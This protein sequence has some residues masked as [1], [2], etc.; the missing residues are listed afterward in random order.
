LDI[1]FVADLVIIQQDCIDNTGPATA[2]QGPNLLMCQQHGANSGER[3]HPAIL[4]RQ[5]N[6]SASELAT[7]FEPRIVQWQKSSV[8]S[9]GTSDRCPVRVEHEFRVV[10][11]VPTIRKPFDFLAE[12]LISENSRGNKTAIELFRTGVRTLASQLSFAGQALVAILD[13]I[14]SERHSPK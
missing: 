1:P 2:R 4:A 9:P 7:G 14:C 6:L 12:G 5:N 11:S 8:D 10:S 13:G 3:L